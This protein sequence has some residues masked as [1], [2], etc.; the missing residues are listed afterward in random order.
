[1]KDTVSKYQTIVQAA[2]FPRGVL[3][4]TLITSKSTCEE[5]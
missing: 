3:A 4:I 1:M 2:T 5:R